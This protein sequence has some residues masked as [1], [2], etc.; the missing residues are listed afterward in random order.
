MTAPTTRIVVP[1]INLRAHPAGFSED[2]IGRPVLH[3]TEA[4]PARR[5]V[6]EVRCSRIRQCPETLTIRF[7]DGT[8]VPAGGFVDL[9]N[10]DPEVGK[11]P[12]SVL[13]LRD[14]V[15]SWRGGDHGATVR[16]ISAEEASVVG[17]ESVDVLAR[18]LGDRG[19]VVH[20]I[21]RFGPTP[22]VRVRILL[23]SGRFGVRRRRM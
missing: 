11:S 23:S 22:R 5:G 16:K 17:A 2:L 18:F 15:L 7:A 9:I 21:D 19:H 6:L 20:S 3:T 8:F 1:A 14:D 4:G 12:K 13:R 10:P